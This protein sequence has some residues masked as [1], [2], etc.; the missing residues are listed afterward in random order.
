ML[1][2]SLEMLM[3][4]KYLLC[5]VF[6]KMQISQ[7]SPIETLFASKTLFPETSSFYDNL[8]MMGD[9]CQFLSYN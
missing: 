6:I 2:L 4:T 5:I 8:F 3:N 1:R 9:R 7:Y